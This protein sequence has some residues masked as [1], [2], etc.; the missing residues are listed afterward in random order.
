MAEKLGILNQALFGKWA[1]RAAIN[2][3]A[4]SL[5]AVEGDMGELRKLV[6]RQSQEILQLR[7]M[8]MGVVEVLHAKAPFDDVE[9]EQA[10]DAAWAKLN[11]PPPPTPTATDPYRGTPVEA[12]AADVEAAKA[13]LAS[14][15]QHHFSQRFA[16]A[17]TI[18]QQIVDQY[19]A[20]KQAA[21]AKQQLANLKKV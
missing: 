8:F 5:Q 17:R 9:L 2:R 12:P 14:A 4:E 7:A 6:Q 11:P 20:T 10:V 16:E 3:N 13:L 21:T 19:G 1:D 15:Q 18:Y